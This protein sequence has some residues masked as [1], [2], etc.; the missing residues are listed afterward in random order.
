MGSE[1][2]EGTAWTEIDTLQDLE[3]AQKEI[4]PRWFPPKCVNRR[5]S[6]LFFPWISRLP[7]TPN[8]WTLIGLVFGLSALSCW[9]EGGT[10]L[11]LLGALLF[12]LFYWADNWDGDLARLRGLCSPFGTWLD[13]SVDFVVQTALPVAIA[14]GLRAVGAEPWV[15]AVGWLAAIGMA[16]DFSVTFWAKARGFGPAVRFEPKPFSADSPAWKRWLQTNWTNENFSIILMLVFLLDLRL[17]FLL[18]AAVGCQVYWIQ[19]L[20]RE[21]HRLIQWAS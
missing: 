6:D 14:A 16:M 18:A 1:S 20:W 3:R 21:R 7:L 15:T 9:S 19:F 5:L 12:Q 11:G 8:H 2:V 17:P 10:S 13:L 4:F